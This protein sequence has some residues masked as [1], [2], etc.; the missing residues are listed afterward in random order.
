MSGELQRGQVMFS[1][2][3]GSGEESEILISGYPAIQEIVPLFCCF[4]KVF[5]YIRL[6]CT[7]GFWV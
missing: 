6:P 7:A 4:E 2:S 3:N 1:R 5:E